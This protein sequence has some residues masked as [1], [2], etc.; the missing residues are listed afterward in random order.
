MYVGD[1]PRVP[2]LRALNHV[3][4]TVPDLAAAIEDTRREHDSLGHRDVPAQ[5]YYGAH[6]ARALLNFPIT[7]MPIAAYPHLVEA[8]AAVKAGRRAGQR[9]ARPAPAA[10]RRRRSTAAC[11]EI[12]S[13]ALHDQFVVDVIQ[14]GAGTSTNMNANEVIANRALEMLGPRQGR[15]RAPAPERARQPE[16]VHQRRLPHRR[17]HRD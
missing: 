12:R 11:A 2:T 17:Q 15:V 16:P 1:Q 10:D 3:A 7:G 8:L 6:T 9:R 14:G 5:A 4:S 13:G